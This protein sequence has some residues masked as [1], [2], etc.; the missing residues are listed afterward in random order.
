MFKKPF[1]LSTVNIS[2][3]IKTTLAISVLII[4][5]FPV[6]AKQQSK[7]N[8]ESTEPTTVEQKPAL[9]ISGKVMVDFRQA[10]DL[11]LDDEFSDAVLRRLDIT[12]EYRFSELWRSEFQVAYDQVEEKI[13]VKDASISTKYFS[14]FEVTLGQFKEP[15]GLEYLTSSTKVGAM[16]RSMATNTFA[17]KRNAGLMFSDNQK[18]YTWAVGVFNNSEDIDFE[19]TAIT[20]RATYNK[21][22]LLPFSQTNKFRLHLGLSASSRSQ[23]PDDSI[24][25]NENLELYGS[26]S[27]IESEKLDATNQSITGLEFALIADSIVLQGEYFNQK[28]TTDS[29]SPDLNSEYDG[30]YTQMTYTITGE[31]IDYKNG[32][33]GGLKPESDYGALS[34]VVRYGALN[35]R[36]NYIGTEATSLYYGLNYTYNKRLRAQLGYQQADITGKNALLVNQGSATS[37]RLQYSF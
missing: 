3:A 11:Y 21:K 19:Q 34:L 18:R 7:L 26:N 35:A 14:A 24:R 29:D 4:V 27:V 12:A 15:M 22:F 17:P 8:S 2:A 28:V 9:E 32:K 25:I 1:A 37:L 6:V 5:A 10:D 30:F 23:D 13:E 31:E 36:D 20:A 33:L 16:E